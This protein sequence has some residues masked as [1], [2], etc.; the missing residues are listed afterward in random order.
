MGETLWLE[1]RFLLTRGN[2]TEGA[3]CVAD[4]EVVGEE[5]AEPVAEGAD[6]RV[7]W[8]FV[9]VGVGCG[10]NPGILGDVGVG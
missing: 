1:T 4:V 9:A 7:L 10:K 6:P 5:V 2:A 8:G 3:I